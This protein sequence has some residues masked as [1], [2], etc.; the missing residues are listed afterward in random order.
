[1]FKCDLCDGEPQCVR[2][3]DEKAVDYVMVD[4]VSTLKKRDAAYRLSAAE[5]EGAVLLQQL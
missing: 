1:V 4:D 3:C 5:K 2:F